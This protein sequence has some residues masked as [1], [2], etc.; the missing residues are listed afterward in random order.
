MVSDV[1]ERASSRRHPSQLF[2]RL[3]KYLNVNG[4]GRPSPAIQFAPLQRFTVR[5]LQ[6]RSA[7]AREILAHIRE[8]L[9]R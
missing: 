4:G 2:P 8:L 6:G 7:Q 3:D 9:R 1:G 5:L